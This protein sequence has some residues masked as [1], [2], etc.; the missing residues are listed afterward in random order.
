MASGPNF[1][2]GKPKSQDELKKWR[3][4]LTY[5]PL[6]VLQIRYRRMAE[7]C[8]NPQRLPTPGMIQEFVTIWKVLRRMGKR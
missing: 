1:S 6:Q 7:A 5:L 2:D 3:D 4:A 8:G